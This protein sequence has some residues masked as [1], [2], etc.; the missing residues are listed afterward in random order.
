MAK[1]VGPINLSGS[2]AG[3]TLYEVNGQF[4][5]RRKS[6]LT[7]KKFKTDPAF[8]GSRA[9]AEKFGQANKLASEVYK[10]LL[11]SERPKE[12]FPQLKKAALQLFNKGMDTAAIKT[13]L[14]AMLPIRTD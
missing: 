10:K 9:S 14:E 5:A 13:H 3:I 12:L 1:Q 11:R 4:Y 2:I 6:S 7:K 8:K